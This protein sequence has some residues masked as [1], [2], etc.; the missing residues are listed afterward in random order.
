[1][2][3]VR[4]N[5]AVDN[6]GGT[7]TISGNC[8]FTGIPYSVVVKTSGVKRFL[9]GVHAQTAFPELNSDDREFLISGISPKGWKEMFG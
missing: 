6:P 8:V 2:Y 1:M 3:K 5:S 7:T 9:D 4:K